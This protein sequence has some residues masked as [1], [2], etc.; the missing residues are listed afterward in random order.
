MTL[1]ELYAQIDGDYAEAVGR[2]RA[3]SLISRFILRFLDDKSC[4]QVQ[5]AWASGDERATFH[6]SH[7]AKGVCANLS[8]TKLGAIAGEICEATR[9]GNEAL[10]A[11]TDI[12]GLVAE[13]AELY[14]RTVACIKEYQASL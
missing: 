4:E 12:D 11:Q 7:S 3:D 6:A 1:Q 13:L 5:Q 2:L 14:A 10:R 8:L 9:E